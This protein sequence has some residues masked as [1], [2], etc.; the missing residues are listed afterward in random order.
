MYLLKLCKLVDL[1]H[2]F[3]SHVRDTAVDHIASSPGPL[4]SCDHGNWTI[5][6]AGQKNWDEK[7]RNTEECFSGFA[8]SHSSSTFPIHRSP[9][10]FVFPLPLV[11]GC[12][13]YGVGRRHLVPNIPNV[14]YRRVFA[15][16]QSHSDQALLI[17]NNNK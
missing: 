1:R 3:H 6:F 4:S 17:I 15:S 12:T 8:L 16:M 7:A 10:S 9:R 2:F 5:R 14:L 13:D 11:R